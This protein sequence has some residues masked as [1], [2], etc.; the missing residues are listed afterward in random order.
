LRELVNGALDTGALVETGGLWRLEGALAPS[1]RLVELVALRLWLR[2]R[3]WG[4]FLQ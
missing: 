4:R 2:L 3:P 1:V